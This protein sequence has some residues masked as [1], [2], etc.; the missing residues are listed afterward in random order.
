MTFG[1][2]LPLVAALGAQAA[3][4][5]VSE[6]S[7]MDDGLERKAQALAGL[8]MNVVG[9]SIAFDDTKSVGDGLGFV[10]N[11]ADFGFAA[12][13][14]QAGKPIAFKGDR[15]EQSAV[16]LAPVGDAT[17]SRVG[18]LLVAGAP[19]R[20]D[21]KQVG[22]VFVGLRTDEVHAEVARM[23]V[24]AAAI[25]IIGISIA[26]IVVVVLAGKI[27]RRNRQMRLVLDNVDEAL[28]TIRKDGTLEPECSAAYERWFGTPGTGSF[29]AQVAADDE[30]MRE[31]LALAWGELVDEVLPIELLVE[32]FPSR[33]DRDGKHFRMDVKPMFERG[34]F[35]GALLR[36]RDI[37]TE[38]E[39]QR[40]LAAQREYVAVF[41]RALSDPHGVREFIEDTGKLVA[42]I[43]AE[44][45]DPVERKRAAHTIKG[46]A[47]VYGV[48]SVAEA[49]H[50]LE[51]Q[52][53]SGQHG[54]AASV[55]TLVTAWTSLASR[56]E[57]LLGQGRDHVDVPRAD[58]EALAELAERGGASAADRLRALL[59]EPV[60]TRFDGFR[61]QIHRVAERL[62]KPVPDVTIDAA[63]V[64]LPPDRLRA[65][66]GAFA[67]L[68]RNAVDHG[69]ES[70]EDRMAAGKPEAGTIRL[71]A[72]LDD[73]VVKIEVADDGRGVA[74][75]RVRDKARAA[76]L[77]AETRE[78]LERALFSDGLSTAD[79]VSETSGRGVGLAAVQAAVRAIGGRVAVTSEAGAGTRFT[80]TFIAAPS[81][82]A[83]RW[84]QPTHPPTASA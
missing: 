66:W 67:H 68:I 4:T 60:A 29:W 33:L 72:S 9:P 15:V 74:W 13:L 62:G 27:V 47:A 38:V 26:V 20:T 10:T 24:W 49:A 44:L 5:L 16:Q 35:A 11:D 52:M 18:D 37:T 41:E 82:R 64:R 19:V 63:G 50:A 81:A 32:Q 36:I 31:M 6:R 65:F 77:P 58:I 57:Q 22:T 84:S 61:R 83:R 48:Q 71:A 70:A 40:T 8:M 17:V 78:D 25:S 59:L 73:G 30:R 14:D 53:S 21:G 76:G 43:P 46:N 12:A 51:D 75:D 45:E 42:A 69:L 1:A 34:V 39:T 7:A 54:D 55:T 28:A 23:S 79:H 3:Y 2:L 80:F 56:V